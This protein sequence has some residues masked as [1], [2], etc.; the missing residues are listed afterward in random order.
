MCA[1]FRS[2]QDHRIP[3]S[4]TRKKSTEVHLSVDS[5]E[6]VDFHQREVGLLDQSLAK[7]TLLFSQN[8]SDLGHL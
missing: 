3:T 1:I 5:E 6:T 2:K 4:K 8:C 7:L